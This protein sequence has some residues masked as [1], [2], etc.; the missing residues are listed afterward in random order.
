M[1]IPGMIKPVEYKN[2]I[3]VD[4]GVSNP[5]P[6]D[7]VRQMG[8]DIVVAVNLDNY[9]KTTWFKKGDATSIAKVSSRSFDLMRHHLA[10][11]SI[12]EADIIIEPTFKENDANIWK[13]YFWD[14]VGGEEIIE[15][16][17]A[18]AKLAIKKIKKLLQ[19]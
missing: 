2:K 19:S 9:E 3:L 5:V 16:G 7:V 1:A 10:Q 17:R 18:E 4:G 14:G 11:K 12:I 15:A 13:K 8:A 6:V